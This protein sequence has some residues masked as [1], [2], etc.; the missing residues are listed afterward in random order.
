LSSTKE[1]L[2]YKAIRRAVDIVASADS[3]VSLKDKLD[4]I[5]RGTARS[6]S[7]GASLVLLDTT[8]K[9]LIHASS[10]AL[11]QFYL[12][13][14]VLD[15]DKSLS[16][17]ITGRPV[18]IADVAR[19]GRIQYPEI[20][21]KAG[22]I[23]ILGVPVMSGDSPVGS[24]RVYA[25]QRYDFTNQ[26]ISFVVTMANLASIAFS[27]SRQHQDN[28]THTVPLRQAQSVTFANPS[29][30]ELARILNFY[31]I[32]WVYEPKSFPLTW[33][34][35]RI[36]EMFTPDFYLPGLDLYIEVTTLKQSL[37]TKKNRKLRLLKQLYPEVKIMLLHKS[38]YANLLARYG[39]GPLAHT[40]ARGISRVLYSSTQIEEKVQALAKQIYKDYAGRHPIMIGVQ[41]G[42]ICFMA[43]LIRQI[44]IPLDID[45]MTISY[46]SGSNHSSF[47][48]TK[49][50]DLNIADR[51]VI[52]V[53]DIIDTGMTLI[54]I[55]NNLRS[56]KPASLAVCTLLDKR[57]HRIV[58][59]PLDYVGFVVREEFVVGYGLDY[60]EEY[61]NLPFIGVPELERP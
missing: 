7:A 52:V 5:V 6:L 28:T 61:R 47:R 27:Q 60:K 33:E 8:G 14:G 39:C 11:P 26:D 34:G 24:I 18:V 41:R 37:V 2:C 43:D 45:L 9:K 30:E 59:I 44:T 22:I 25:K 4:T 31:N 50:L 1:K 56:R 51:H 36:T 38:E 54:S 20:A 10:W 21:A 19:D 49:D 42:F 12:R 16:E 53:E 58:D 32:E 23:S 17:I 13:K 46:Y 55:L 35:D 15:A 40:R 29:E 57:T 3:G 48:I